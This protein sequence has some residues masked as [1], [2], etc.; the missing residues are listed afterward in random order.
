MNQ[1]LSFEITGMTCE[2]C[3]ATVTKALRQCPGVEE[4]DVTLNPGRALV[5]GIGMDPEQLVQAV[6]EAGFMA[7]L[8]AA[9]NDAAAARAMA[10][11]VHERR[12]T[13]GSVPFTS[14]GGPFAADLL[15]IGGGS[16]GFAAAIR[17]HELGA[18]A[19]LINAG[20]IGG[21]CVNVGASPRR[22]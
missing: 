15:V 19:I 10:S 2:H 22:R 12:P 7:G 1:T 21:T 18:R 16:A 11:A 3:L 4:V 5:H 8:A 14:H 9:G 17:A 13:T 6:R 20:A